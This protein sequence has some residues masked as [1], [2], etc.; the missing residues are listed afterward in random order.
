MTI[1]GL[2]ASLNLT[3]I[4]IGSLLCWCVWHG[5]RW[6]QLSTQ[7]LARPRAVF[8]GLLTPVLIL[9]YALVID[10]LTR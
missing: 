5:V 9:P 2:Q 1:L 3:H 7:R 4:V 8:V 6:A 10:F